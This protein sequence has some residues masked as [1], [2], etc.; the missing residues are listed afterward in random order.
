MKGVTLGPG[1]QK[2]KMRVQTEIKLDGCNPRPPLLLIML[3]L[4]L[5]RND[6]LGFFV[7]CVC[8]CVCVI[9]EDRSEEG[10]TIVTSA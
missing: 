2:Y 8:V 6:V 10:L 7:M 9:R 1:Y 5:F 3:S 4:K